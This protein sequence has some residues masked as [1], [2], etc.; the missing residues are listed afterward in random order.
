MSDFE[1]KL[2]IASDRDGTVIDK[3]VI[4]GK[5]GERLLV[6]SLTAAYIYPDELLRL[7]KWSGFPGFILNPVSVDQ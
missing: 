4:T 3:I 5:D 7:G 1:V 6:K 2:E